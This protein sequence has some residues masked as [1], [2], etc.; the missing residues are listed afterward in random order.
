MIIDTSAVA[1]LLFAEPTWRRVR[2]VLRH[3]TGPRMLSAGT[4][5]EL[6][7]VV[8]RELGP[9]GLDAMGRLIH[10]VPI[11]IAPVTEE[12]ARLAGEAYL[13][14]GKGMGHPAQLNFG[15]CF[16]Y[17]L[18]K[19]TGEPLLC[20]GNDFARTDLDLVHVPDWVNE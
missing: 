1:A 15:D 9:T 17:A 2:H 12:D 11:D 19:R 3:E 20:L 10:S 14:Y 18:A 16:G 7:I 6:N 13:R 4:L 8:I 5:V